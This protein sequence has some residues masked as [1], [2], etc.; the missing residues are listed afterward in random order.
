MSKK[1]HLNS[2]EEEIIDRMVKDKTFRIATA[3]KSHFW[4]FHYYLGP[5]YCKYATADFQR[6]ILNLTERDDLQNILITAF[7]GSAKSTL[8][9]LSYVLWSIVGVKQKKFPVILGHTQLSTQI[10]LNALKKELEENADFRRDFGP[11][12]EHIDGGGM[13]SII[14][15]QY[16][17]NITT[18]SI[19]QNIR[20][21]KHSQ[22]RPDL[23]IC[24][25]IEDSESVK[26]QENRDK[27]FD[28]LTGDVI[29]AGDRDTQLVFIG[30]PLHNDSVLMRLKDIFLEDPTKSAFR[31]YPI[32]DSESIPLWRGK[33]SNQTYI[34]NEKSKCFNELLWRR[35][36][37]LEI[38][39]SDEQIIKRSH[40][41]Y[42][43]ELPT[44]KYRFSAVS[45]DPARSLKSS[46]DCTAMVCGKLYRYGKE[47]MLCI[48]PNPVNDRIS[49]DDLIVKAK[50]LALA[51]NSN[52]NY[53]R[54]YVED[55]GFQGIIT[56]LLKSEG[57]PARSIQLRGMSKQDRLATV[58]SLIQLGCIR[59]AEK[60]N[61]KL[62]E[63]I[64]GLGKEKHDDLVD[65]FT[66][67]ILQMFTDS[68]KPQPSIRFIDTRPRPDIW[69]PWN[70]YA[71]L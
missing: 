38:V 58:S 10:H 6:E 41:H 52:T 4:F 23:I 42:Y 12:K 13:Q 54:V 9:T 49:T 68:N 3:R 48:M 61:E 56:D 50:G 30:T 45:I 66:M 46:A 55:V 1:L 25:D 5:R 63:Q 34:D 40:I 24:D 70:P 57:I 39:E 16:G 7:R 27:L 20:G 26:T 37:L 22:Y 31:Q 71:N 60:G 43:E 59:F 44:D 64:L 33:F 29:P 17:A 18:R 32:I 14:L 36:Y 11:F 51:L 21:I 47:R 8:I 15:P 69:R 65:A 67:L 2:R 62:I 19:G 53:S 35:E 28:W